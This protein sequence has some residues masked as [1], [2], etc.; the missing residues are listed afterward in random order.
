MTQEG[1]RGPETVPAFEPSLALECWPDC[2]TGSLREGPTCR[3]QQ[4][5]GED[6]TWASIP[7]YSSI[8]WAREERP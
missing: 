4:G 5:M 8:A 6:C 3:Q 1:E 7:K 2:D